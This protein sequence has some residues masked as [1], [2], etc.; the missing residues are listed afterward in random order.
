LTGVE[1][2]GQ[3][4]AGEGGDDAA[5]WE[6]DVVIGDDLFGGLHGG[7]DLAA[8]VHEVVAVEELHVDDDEVIGFADGFPGAEG[9]DSAVFALTVEEQMD[10]RALSGV[11]AFGHADVIVVLFVDG[12][13]N[14]VCAASVGVG[15]GGRRPDTHGASQN[16]GETGA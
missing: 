9:F 4:S 2:V 6:D 5:A 8:G 7:P 13:V 3:A 14:G 1:G 10:A 15:G 16:R 12:R 11:V